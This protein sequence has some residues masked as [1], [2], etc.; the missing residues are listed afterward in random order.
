MSER[1]ATT[2]NQRLE[3]RIGTLEFTHDFASGYP[4][5]QTIDTLYNERDFQRACQAY[6]W[7]LP[8]VSFTTWYEAQAAFGAGNGEIVAYL[9]YDDRL[10]IVTANATTPYYIAFADLS[11]GPL[12]MDMPP[13]GVLGGIL[14]FWQRTIPDSERPARYLVLGPGQEQP[15]DVAGFEVRRSQTMGILLGIRITVADPTD[16]QNVLS[17]FRVYPYAQRDNPPPTRIV[18][19]NGRPWSATPPRGLAYWER[20]HEAIQREP[21]EERDRFFYAMLKLLGIAKGV[22]F[23]PD[24][25]QTK[26]LTEGALIGEAMAKAN[27]FE[28]R[29]AGVSYRP[30]SRW[31]NLLLLDADDPDNFWNL[32]DERAAWFYE[33]VT[34]TPAMAPKRPG[35]ASAYLGTYRDKDGDWLDGSA[36]YRLRVPADPP[37]ALFW[38]ITA[39]DVDTRCFI[40]NAEKIADRSSRMDLRKN[41]DGSIDIYCGPNAPAGFEENWIPTVPGRN[42]FAYFRFYGP[43][44]PY[45]DRSWPLGDFERMG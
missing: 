44:Q 4:T 40:R 5:R 16:V 32:L 35:P 24:E 25:R 27:T 13:R 7:A 43:T 37:V 29:F 45:F 30:D 36:T 34:A 31:H 1:P 28:R 8:L 22:P 9:S 3:T 6:L 18:S 2:S 38:S 12:I 17:Q 26:L 11:A 39:Y 21:A 42:W 10:G 33:A 23:A 20:L 41:A 14:D 19:P 15:E